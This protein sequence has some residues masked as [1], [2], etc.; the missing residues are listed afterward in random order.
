MTHFNCFL[1]YEE[2]DAIQFFF[3]ANVLCSLE[4]KVWNSNIFLFAELASQSTRNISDFGFLLR[5]TLLYFRIRFIPGRCSQKSS[6]WDPPPRGPASTLLFTILE[7]KGTPFVYLLPP[8]D[9]WYPFYMLLTA[10]N[11]PS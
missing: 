1:L 10:L 6:H 11:A 8:V 7:R 9:K 4:Q 3:I 5:K 2:I